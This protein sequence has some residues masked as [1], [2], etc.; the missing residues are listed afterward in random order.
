M[1]PDP[2]KIAAIS[3]LSR[4]QSVTDIRA[5]VGLVGFYRRFIPG[6][7]KIA[8]P[9]TKLTAKDEPFT[10]GEEQQRAFE[11]LRQQLSELTLLR[12]PTAE[13]RFRVYTDYCSSALGAALH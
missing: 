1:K 5:F 7:A 3:R 11:S 10:W 9:L 2:E 4:P 8:Q 12:T 13:G 6:F